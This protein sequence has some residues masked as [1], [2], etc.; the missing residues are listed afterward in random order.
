VEVLKAAIAL[1][2]SL[3]GPVVEIK[4]DYAVGPVAALYEA[5]GYQARRT[6]WKSLL[7]HRRTIPIP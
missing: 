6:W 5:E 4:D 2:N 1:D 7:D 3:T